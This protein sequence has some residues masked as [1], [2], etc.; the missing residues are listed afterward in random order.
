[1]KQKKSTEQNFSI[2]NI[3]FNYAESEDE[4]C[5]E[6]HIIEIIIKKLSWQHSLNGA[7]KF[8]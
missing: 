6:K 1:M 4:L 7:I 5:E 3:T 8:T 2:T